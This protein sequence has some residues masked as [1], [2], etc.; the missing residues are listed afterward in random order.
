MSK[1]VHKL[2][3]KY[4]HVI[5]KEI[6]ILKPDILIFLTGPGLDVY[7]GYIREN[8]TVRGTPKPLAQHNVNAVSKLNIAEVKL[9]YKTYHPAAHITK[10]EKWDYYH[11]I[12]DD[13]KEHIHDIFL[14]GK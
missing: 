5:P 3:E 1:T 9:A 7:Y 8:F 13:M 2:E 4:F 6:E 11:A 14:K 10:E 12:L